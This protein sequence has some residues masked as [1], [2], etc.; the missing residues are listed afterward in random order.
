MAHA[1]S[2]FLDSW[3]G[4]RTP[5][6]AAR[7]GVPQRGRVEVGV[8]WWGVMKGTICILHCANLKL[9]L[10]FQRVITLQK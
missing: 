3:K 6:N 2:S 5:Y 7:V 9:T 8:E 4:S 1:W 10:K